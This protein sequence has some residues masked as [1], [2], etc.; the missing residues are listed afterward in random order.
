MFKADTISFLRLLLIV[1]LF[2]VSAA[3]LI[4]TSPQDAGAADPKPKQPQQVTQ[5]TSPKTKSA[6]KPVAPNKEEKP[7]AIKTQTPK[8]RT[9]QPAPS[10]AKPAPGTGKAAPGIQPT[11]PRMVARRPA[12]VAGS[13]FRGTF[14][15]SLKA[16][17]FPLT[18][19]DA[20]PRFFDIVDPK[21]G[22]R[23][24]TTRSLER[25]SEKDHYYDSSVLFHIP[26]HFN[27]NLPF[28]YVV[29]F[30]GNRS[31]V[32][33][34][35]TDY[36]L[37][38]QVN[39]SGKNVILVLPQLARNAADSSPGKFSKRNAF[40]TFMQEAAQV[41]SAKL[42][43]KHHKQIEQAPVILVAFSGGYKPLACTLD[44]GGTDSRIKGILLLDGLYEDLYIFGKWLLQRSM[45]SFFVNI[46]TEESPCRDKTTALAQ[47][48]REHRLPFRESWPRS[49]RNGQIV[50]LSSPQD[51]LQVP[52]AGPPREP[53]AELLRNLKN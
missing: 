17:P 29:F 41:L 8:Q 21:T 43:R 40:R 34:T 49:V 16:A 28:S 31:D 20:D 30:H 52:I 44:R 18:G 10:T 26:P 15:E 25:L 33:Q 35:V 11:V 5:G 4:L 39:R 27:P 6:Q 51:H 19:K 32:R 48:L 46:Y 12:P 37:D 24:R 3:C 9:E 53:L 13:Q 45:V 50:L 1:G 7:Q 23:Y 2:M 14:V 47:F 42:G 36:Q 22:E 38:E